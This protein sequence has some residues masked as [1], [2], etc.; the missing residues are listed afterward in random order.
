MARLPGLVIPGLPY[1][2]TQRG[3]RRSQ[4]FFEDGDYAL[5]RDL[6]AEAAAKQRRRSGPIA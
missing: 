4:T 6:L 3:D 1:H 2:V 5:Y